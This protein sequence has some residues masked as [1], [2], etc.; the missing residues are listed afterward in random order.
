VKVKYLYHDPEDLELT[1]Q[2]RNYIKNY[3]T[4]FENAVYGSGFSNPSTGYR[5]YINTYSFIDFF[6][7]E[8]LGRTVDGYRSSSFMYKDKDSK[9]GKLTCGPMWDFNLSYGNADYCDAYDTTNWQYNFA[10][11]CPSFSS[12]PPNWW[13]RLLQDT[14]Y[15]HEMRCRWHDL[16][17]GILATPSINTWIDS[18]ALYLDESQQRNFIEW[19]ILGTYIDWNYYVGATYQDEVDYLKW[20]LQVRSEYMD[21]N[22]PGNCY[23]A[24]VAELPQDVTVKIF[25]N[26]FSASAHISFN[27]F[28]RTEKTLVLYDL[29]GQE[30]KKITIPESA[31]SAT[32]ER[33]DLSSGVYLYKLFDKQKVLA[34]GKIIVR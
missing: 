3:V 7:M 27:Y 22:L 21:G 15:V 26:P 23:N 25:P 5:A 29:L 6:L 32:I 11:V 1:V 2:Q 4:S 16:R 34:G 31:Y 12:E 19:P 20:W 33:G 30:I 10:S 14:N 28:E 17:I 18:V 24:S 9:G 8:E 13:N